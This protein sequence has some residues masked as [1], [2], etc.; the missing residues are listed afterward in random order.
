VRDDILNAARD[1][2]QRHGFRKT[3]MDDIATP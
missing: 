2:I 1:I 3:T